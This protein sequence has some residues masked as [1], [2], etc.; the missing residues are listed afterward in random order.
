MTYEE[1][2]ALGAKPADAAPKGL[3]YE[4]LLDLGAKPQ[5]V[6]AGPEARRVASGG[7]MRPEPKSDEELGIDDGPQFGFTGYSKA[8][9]RG[10]AAPKGTAILPGGFPY[11]PGVTDDPIGNDPLAGMIV[12][13]IPAAGLGTLAGGL[14]KGAPAVANAVRGA[15]TGAASNPDHPLVGAAVGVLPAVPGLARSADEAIGRKAAEIATDPSRSL[16]AGKVASA[17]G[18]YAG[19]AAGGAVGHSVGGLPG[20][21]VG[22]HY[23]GKLGEQAAG[24]LAGAADKAVDALAARWL[25]RQAPKA[26]EAAGVAAVPGLSAPVAPAA[27]A[28][29]PMV[30]LQP[31]QHDPLP[32]PQGVRPP[33]M[34]DE[35][36]GEPVTEVGQGGF[37]DSEPVTAAGKPSLRADVAATAKGLKDAPYDAEAAPPDSVSEQ[38]A[39]SVQILGD[40]QKAKAANK[41]TPTMI[42]GAIKAGMPPGAVS[43]AAGRE[44][45]DRAMTS[46]LT[47]SGKALERVKRGVPLAKAVQDL[48]SEGE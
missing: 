29:P 45:F 18:K 48:E 20:A 12:Q 7:G 42:Q 15:V 13:S 32:T 6:D 43:K 36:S 1:L 35:I 28:A 46:D 40:L 23:G 22:Q 16:G 33:P 26:A 27:E 8:G 37:L 30:R 44:A 39:R 10:T 17:V 5:T 9:A 4:Q 14:V 38:L 34:L 11:Q 47:F 3:T 19:K 31:L 24:K 21:A 41:L 25:A 2:V